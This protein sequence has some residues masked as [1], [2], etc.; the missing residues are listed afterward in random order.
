MQGKF[1]LQGDEQVFGS[2]ADCH[3]QLVEEFSPS[4]SRENPGL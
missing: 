3:F 4:L 1:F 2:W